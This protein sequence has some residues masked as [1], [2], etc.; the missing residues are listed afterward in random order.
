MLVGNQHHF[1]ADEMLCCLSHQD[2]H[3]AV[4][5]ETYL[6]GRIICMVYDFS[7]EIQNKN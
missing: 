3:I 1:L 2:R 7:K 5:N 4:R 6:E